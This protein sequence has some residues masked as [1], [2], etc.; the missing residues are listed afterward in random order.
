MLTCTPFL[1]A[2]RIQGKHYLFDSMLQMSVAHL[3]IYSYIKEQTTSIT[4]I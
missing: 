1:I 3:E 2:W 4:K